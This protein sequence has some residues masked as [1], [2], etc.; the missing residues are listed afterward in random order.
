MSNI[1]KKMYNFIY[2]YSLYS[3]TQFFQNYLSKT[4]LFLESEYLLRWSH[5]TCSK[6]CFWIEPWVIFV[7]YS[8]IS[9]TPLSA[10]SLTTF[11]LVTMAEDFYLKSI[12]VPLWWIGRKKAGVYFETFKEL[13]C[14]LTKKNL[15]GLYLTS[16]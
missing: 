16:V 2:V 14:V 10:K 3:K 9:R 11:M 15:Q 13:H 12:V 5:T 8:S 4:V 1:F 7:L 6:Y